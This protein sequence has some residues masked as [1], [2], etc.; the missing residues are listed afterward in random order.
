M[1]NLG[2]RMREPDVWKDQKGVGFQ[3]H[4]LRELR[5][6]RDY[7]DAE[8]DQ[9]NKALLTARASPRPLIILAVIV[10]CKHPCAFTAALQQ[11][12]RLTLRWKPPC[13]GWGFVLLALNTC[14]ASGEISFG[15]EKFSW[16]EF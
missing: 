7:Q 9:P 1:K 14:T 2:R 4:G 8:E 3:V 5:S 13:L 12:L 16:M 11:Q 6:R 15:R 10:S